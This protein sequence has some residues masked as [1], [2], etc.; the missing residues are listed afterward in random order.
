M[1]YLGKAHLIKIDDFNVE[2]NS[3]DRKKIKSE[4]D[5]FY[6]AIDKTINYIDT[7][8]DSIESKFQKNE[9]I[10]LIAFNKLILK[11]PLIYEETRKL[12]RT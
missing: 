8:I 12:L 11:D 6:K 7:S 1:A 9:L 2:F 5:R 4:I 10:A 3:I